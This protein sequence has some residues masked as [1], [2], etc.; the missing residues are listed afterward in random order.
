MWLPIRVFVGSALIG[1]AA[2]AQPGSVLSSPLARSSEAGPWVLVDTRGR[3]ISDRDLK[4]KP[5]VLFFGFT[6]CSEICPVGLS[7]LT[8]WMR[9]LG[10]DADRL[11]VVFVTVDPERDTP[12]VLATYLSNFD[13][14]IRG[15]T[16][17]PAQVAIAAQ[18]YG[19]SYEKIPLGGDDYS[20]RHSMTIYLTNR[21]GRVVNSI[22][23]QDTNEAAL[24]KLRRISRG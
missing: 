6:H 11:N 9:A 20:I 18:R 19:V 22:V 16:G 13:A 17:T 23:P 3:S 8:A 7:A 2:A 24:E 14:R 21:E 1:L 10:K 4:G 5:S 15:L 12:A